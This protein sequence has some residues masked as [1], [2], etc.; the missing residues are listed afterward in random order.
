[1]DDIE[2]VWGVGLVTHVTVD[3]FNMDCFTYRIVQGGIVAWFA[4]H[5]R[6]KPA[7]AAAQ[8][9]IK[10]GLYSEMTLEQFLSATL[11]T[12]RPEQGDL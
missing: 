10:T 4:K 3:P 6:L 2:G 12:E 8:L 11:P 7:C 9:Y 1:M 5:N